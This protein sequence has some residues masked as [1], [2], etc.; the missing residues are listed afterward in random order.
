MAYIY[1]LHI[2]QTSTNTTTLTM[3]TKPTY[4]VYVLSPLLRVM[5]SH[6]SGVHTI[7]YNNKSKAH[8]L[9]ILT[10]NYTRKPVDM[11]RQDSYLAFYFFLHFRI[12][13]SSWWSNKLAYIN[14]LLFFKSVWAVGYNQQQPYTWV[15]SICS[16]FIWWSPVSSPTVIP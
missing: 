5:M 8:V 10:T 11:M 2:V 6:F 15:P 1:I 16:L 4:C 7:T 9:C 14:E 3:M 12:W 13:H